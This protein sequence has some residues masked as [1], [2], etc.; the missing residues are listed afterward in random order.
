MA[1]K[2]RTVGARCS[3]IEFRPTDNGVILATALSHSKV[4]GKQ[5]APWAETWG[6]F[7]FLIRELTVFANVHPDQARFL[8]AAL[9]LKGVIDIYDGH[10][11]VLPDDAYKKSVERYSRYLALTHGFGDLEL[12]KKHLGMHM[13]AGANIMGNPRI[14]ANWRDEPLNKTLKAACRQVSQETFDIS[15]L[16]AM[17]KIL[18]DMPD[19]VG[20]ED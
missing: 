4:L 10:G 3:V 8:E 7:L 16:T 13:V 14:F 6:V 20:Q 2:L 17:L 18:E 5:T 1:P 12:P 9:S 11:W 19:F 15:V